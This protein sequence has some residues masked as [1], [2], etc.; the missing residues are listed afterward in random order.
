LFEGDGKVKDKWVGTTKRERTL[1]GKCRLRAPVAKS[2]SGGRQPAASV[3]A[4]LKLG[5]GRPCE[6]DQEVRRKEM[7]K[8]DS[9]MHLKWW[10]VQSQTNDEGPG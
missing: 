6:R 1:K 8:K 9:W 3:S 10:R 5:R 2:N 7:R 4:G